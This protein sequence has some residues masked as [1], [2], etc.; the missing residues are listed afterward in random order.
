M[1]PT[2]SATRAAICEGTEVTVTLSAPSTGTLRVVADGKTYQVELSAQSTA[3][4]RLGGAPSSV[5][6]G[7]VTAATQ[8]SFTAQ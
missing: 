8:P 2:V 1:G 6:A 7:L 4:L 5:S 3:T